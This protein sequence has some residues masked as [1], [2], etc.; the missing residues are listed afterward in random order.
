MSLPKPEGRLSVENASYRPYGAKEPTLT[1]IT[2][3]T[4]L[5]SCTL[6]GATAVTS[7]GY[8]AVQ[9]AQDV[10]LQ[11]AGTLAGD[12]L[13]ERGLLGHRFVDDRP[14]ERRRQRRDAAGAVDRFGGDQHLRQLTAIGAGIGGER[15]T[16]RAGN[17][18][19]EFEA[20]QIGSGGGFLGGLGRG[21]GGLLGG[22]RLLVQIAKGGDDGQTANE[23]GNQAELDDVSRLNLTKHFRQAA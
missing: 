5:A 22:Q 20:G 2:T 9:E 1:A 17:A 23:L 3:R 18:E 6:A 19:I 14:V 13:D 11:L 7:H 21:A 16:D 10:L 15:A 8:L 4:P 12:D